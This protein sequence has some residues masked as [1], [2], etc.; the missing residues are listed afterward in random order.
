LRRLRGGAIAVLTGVRRKFTMKVPL[1]PAV[2]RSP[3]QGA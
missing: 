2:A 3:S 1:A